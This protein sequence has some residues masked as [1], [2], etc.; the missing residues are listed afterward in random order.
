MIKNRLYPYIEKY[1]NEYLYGFTKEQLDIGIMKGIINLEYLNIR[2]DKV[3]SKIDEKNFAFWLKA[4]LISKIT[5][6]CSLMNFIGEKPLEITID[7][8]DVILTPSYKWIIK[9]IESFIE[10]V[11][12]T[13]VLPYDARENNSVDIF[14][15][16]VNIFDNSIF[17]KEILIEIFKDKSKIS[18]MINKLFKNFFKFYYMKNYAVNV[19]IKNIHIRFEDDQLINFI[20]DISLGFKIE[21]VHINLSSE[22]ILKKDYFQLEKMDVYW[23]SK[24]KILIPSTILLTSLNN[25][26]E[27]DEKYYGMLKKLNF[28]NFNYN[29]NTEFLVKNFNCKMNFGIK[30]LNTEKIDLFSNKQKKYLFYVQFASSELNLNFFPD[31]LIIQKNF[32]NFTRTYSVLE[33]VQEFKPMRK[34]FNLNSDLV[35]NLIKICKE[36]KNKKLNEIIDFKRK[37]LVRDWLFY[38]FWCHKCHSSI[39]GKSINPLRLEFS[40]FYNLCFNEW[41]DEKFNNSIDLKKE[42]NTNKLKESASNFSQIS[43][44]LNNEKKG[45]PTENNPNPDNININ[46]K[47]E[48]LIKGININLYPSINTTNNKIKGNFVS[49]KLEGLDIKMLIDLNLFKMNINFKN[50]SFGPNDLIE[51]EKIVLNNHSYRKYNN[52]INNDVLSTMG[53]LARNSALSNNTNNNNN[54]NNNNSLINNL[55]KRSNPNYE[56]SLKILNDAINKV[57]NNNNNNNNN[58]NYN[59]SSFNNKNSS[60]KSRPPTKPQN[61]NNPKQNSFISSILQNTSN[62]SQLSNNSNNPASQ[63]NFS[64]SQKI[65]EYNKKNILNSSKMRN[66][67]NKLTSTGK[68]QKLNFFEIYLPNPNNNNNN[69]LSIDFIK[70]NSEKQPDSI[71]I[72]FGVIHLNL[73]AEYLSTSLS[74]I[75]EYKK[76]TSTPKLKQNE[77]QKKKKIST[78]TSQKQLISMKRYILNYIKNLDEKKKTEQIK[79][80]I[81]YLEKEIEKGDKLLSDGNFEINYIFSYFSNGIE[82][83]INYDNFEMIYYSSDQKN[84]LLGKCLLPM[85]DFKFKLNKQIIIIN[86]F[87]FEFEINDLRNSKEL[88]NTVLKILGDKLKSSTIF[89]EPCLIQMKNEFE[90]INNNNNNNNLNEAIVYENQNYNNNNNNFDLMNK[91]IL[92]IV[93]GNQNNNINNNY[94]KD[95]RGI[96]QTLNENDEDE[97]NINRAMKFNE[98][99]DLNLKDGF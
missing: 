1:I 74:I 99:D 22:G 61:N 71:K 2:P 62:A 54:N 50:I 26:N 92:S 31:L 96:T 32:K 8:F 93:E 38:F 77:N 81:K 47:G 80:Y 53:N 49:F 48:F 15:K 70:S 37:M 18:Q 88:I 52:N 90:K 19:N 3:N 28:G 10:E 75:S 67:Q 98:S 51:G 33:Q 44:T 34:P 79:E 43:S 87:D 58:N 12:K 66:P 97:E 45:K 21:K 29:S 55:L 39:Y 83:N 42:T 36:K 46:F 63:T 57:G 11:Q 4:G 82:V 94:K 40:R 13:I 20:G 7:G 41:E 84:K 76:F 5:V 95:N 78:L 56:K 35:K 27:L 30:N 59:K 68:T 73:F 91:K 24:A 9:N 14:K 17:K 89:I 6:G 86:F 72:N 65:S 85:I 69:C 60:Y 25:L 64:I 23:E 16:K